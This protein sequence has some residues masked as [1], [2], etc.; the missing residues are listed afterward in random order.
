M[1]PPRS[2]KRIPSSLAAQRRRGGLPLLERHDR[3]PVGVVLQVAVVAPQDAAVVV[4]ERVADGQLVAAVA[5]HVVRVG[6]VARA[7]GDV[8]ER[9]QGVGKGPQVPV[10]VLEDDVARPSRSA[11]VAEEEAVAQ[12]AGEG[13]LRTVVALRHERRRDPA[14][15]SAGRP[16]GHDQLL[17]AAVDDLGTAVAVEVVGLEG[18]VVRETVL[19]GVRRAGLPEDAPVERQG[20][21]A[22]EL[23]VAVLRTVVHDL[24]DQDVE[25]TVAV[26]VAEAQVAA[27]AEAVGAQL[28]PRHHAGVRRDAGLLLGPAPRARR[29]EAPGGVRV[30]GH[31]HGVETSRHVGGEADAPLGEGRVA[32]FE[33]DPAVEL[34]PQG[35]ALHARCGGGR[36]RPASWRRAFARGPSRRASGTRRPRSPSRAG[37]RRPSPRRS[38]GR[39]RGGSGR[40]RRSGPPSSPGRSGS[41]A[42]SPTTRGPPPRESGASGSAPSRGAVYACSMSARP[43]SRTTR[44]ARCEPSLRNAETTQLP[45]GASAGR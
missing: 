7:Q 43:S 12:D 21:Q 35:V 2:A 16:L 37:L 28:P 38:S 1:R 17:V 45:F 30:G 36:S 24:A 9:L 22:A 10:A 31:A 34:G 25:A 4:D 26:E 6:V 41:R 15:D 32:G 13:A 29:L 44:H 39:G 40:R 33:G 8:P 3:H 18:D 23:A 19:P 5:V 42:R 27:D 14:Q 11:Q 20:G